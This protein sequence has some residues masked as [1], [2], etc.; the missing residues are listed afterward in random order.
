MTVSALEN[1][2]VAGIRVAR[3]AYAIR[4]AMVHREVSVVPVSRNPGGRVVTGRAGSRETRC[5][6]VRVIRTAVIRLM[7]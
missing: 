1:R 5:R 2:V 7:T 4:V 6:M 3:R